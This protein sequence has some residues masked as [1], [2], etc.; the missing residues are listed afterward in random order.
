MNTLIGDHLGALLAAGMGSNLGSFKASKTKKILK[1][2]FDEEELQENMDWKKSKLNIRLDR[3]LKNNGFVASS[4][5]KKIILYQIRDS[6]ETH[7]NLT[8]FR[9]YVCRSGLLV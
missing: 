2:H 6:I 9:C 5:S 1:T 7:R 4:A 8:N 3:R